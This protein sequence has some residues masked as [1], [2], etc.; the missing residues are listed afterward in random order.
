MYT[1]TLGK[2]LF[3]EEM[4]HIFYCL[5]VPSKTLYFAEHVFV[6]HVYFV[7]IFF[8]NYSVFVSKA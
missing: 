2:K 4:F 5:S 7:Y 3:V 8:K 6:N 1:Y